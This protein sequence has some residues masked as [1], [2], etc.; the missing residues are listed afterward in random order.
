MSVRKPKPESAARILVRELSRLGFTVKYT[1]ALELVAR[2]QGFNNAHAMRAQ[3]SS[4]TEHRIRPD[5]LSL[6]QTVALGNTEYEEVS[7]LANKLLKL[8]N[9]DLQWDCPI[10][11]AHQGPLKVEELR[12]LEAK[13]DIRAVVE[14]DFNYLLDAN[15]DS[16]L[17][18]VSERITGSEAGL[19]DVGY[20]A[21]NLSETTDGCVAVEVT[22]GAITWE[23]IDDTSEASAS[24]S[25]RRVAAIEF[26][27]NMFSEVLE[28]DFD[29]DLFSWLENYRSSSEDDGD[30]EVITYEYDGR[31][32]ENAIT[33]EDLV[34]ATIAQDG[35][36]TFED[37]TEI[38]LIDQNRKRWAPKAKS[39]FDANGR[40]EAK[41]AS[42]IE[43]FIKAFRSQRSL[44]L[45]QQLRDAAMGYLKE[46]LI[47]PSKCD[48]L[49][50]ETASVL[51]AA[52]PDPS[53]PF[54]GC[55]LPKTI[56]GVEIVSSDARAT[57]WYLK[58][59]A[60][61]SSDSILKWLE[62][63]MQSDEYG[64]GDEVLSFREEGVKPLHVEDFV[65]AKLASDGRFELKNGTEFY[66][67]D[68]S[69][70]RWLPKDPI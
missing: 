5:V 64:V 51:N 28:V 2:V 48:E 37:G 58:R 20:R 68:E 54:H 42:G 38:Y 52:Q 9:A 26:I 67:L 39:L 29:G 63:G 41:H 35:K 14:V 12:D 46:G 21:V 69:G 43:Y 6:L 70:K 50:Q 24:P 32:G 4:A 55:K 53:K 27:P 15:L 57:E 36:L 3:K 34:N 56:S 49:L 25:R 65:N 62:E 61:H 1:Q 45:A 31:G 30:L 11:R 8:I 7:E 23:T 59:F 66:L 47:D 13:D 44:R 60:E 33:L 10:V 17:D 22:A 18:F 40:E 19:E 16:F